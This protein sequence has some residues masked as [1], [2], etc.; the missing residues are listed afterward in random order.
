MA[1]DS[2]QPE[3]AKQRERFLSRSDEQRRPVR[4]SVSE[5]IFDLAC[6]TSGFE[7][8][9]STYRFPIAIADTQYQTPDL[10]VA[11]IAK[12]ECCCDRNSLPIVLHHFPIAK[13]DVLNME[14]ITFLSQD[15]VWTGSHLFKSDQQLI[16]T[17]L[18]DEN[19][20]PRA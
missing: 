12:A 17:P 6:D 1:S 19:F 4:L 3:R 20:Q 13:S 2:E 15:P 9:I 11:A 5:F 16:H 14:A 8:S 18:Y 7:I 10:W